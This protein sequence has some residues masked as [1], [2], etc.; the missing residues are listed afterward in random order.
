M[1]KLIHSYSLIIK[2]HARGYNNTNDFTALAMGD[3]YKKNVIAMHHGKE[4]RLTFTT[5]FGKLAQLNV[6]LHLVLTYM[7]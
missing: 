4:H 3:I 5:K 1:I 6:N 7:N 2:T